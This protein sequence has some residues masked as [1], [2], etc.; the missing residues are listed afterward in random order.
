MS[1][2]IGIITFEMPDNKDIQRN[3]YIWDIKTLNHLRI[4][5]NIIKNWTR[6]DIVKLTW[7]NQ[8]DVV[9]HPDR[10]LGEQREFVFYENEQKDNNPN[11]TGSAEEGLYLEYT[12]TLFFTYLSNNIKR[13]RR[14]G[15]PAPITDVFQRGGKVDPNV[16]NMFADV[17]EQVTGIGIFTF[18]SG[19]LRIDPIIE[20]LN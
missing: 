16:G 11:I 19:Y 14:I 3:H 4:Y 5:A 20:D 13:Q 1:R 18:S 8:A 12:A 9:F 15:I 2:R 10:A 6:A 17:L 7:C